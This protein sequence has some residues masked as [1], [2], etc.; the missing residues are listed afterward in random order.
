[1]KKQVSLDNVTL[2]QGLELGE[3]AEVLVLSKAFI[4]KNGVAAIYALRERFHQADIV[5]DV[6]VVSDVHEAELCFDA[7]ADVV[8]V[9]GEASLETVQACASLADDYVER[10]IA[11][12]L[13]HVYNPTKKLDEFA[14]AGVEGLILHHQAA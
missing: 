13:A 2:E 14:Q 12:D 10:C 6:K 4:M 7:G 1:M 11:L 5:A 8:T 9:L 3:G